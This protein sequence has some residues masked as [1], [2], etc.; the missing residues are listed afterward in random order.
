VDELEH[1]VGVTGEDEQMQSL[2]IV[3]FDD[4]GEES[5]LCSGG[6]AESNIISSAATVLQSQSHAVPS[7]TSP[8]Q[9][10]LKESARTAYLNR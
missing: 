10:C 2:K 5:R 4:G 6:L 7:P 9:Y 8:G 1:V 3:A